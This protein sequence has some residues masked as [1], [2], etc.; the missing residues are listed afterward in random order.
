MRSEEMLSMYSGYICKTCKHDFVV[1][2][3]DVRNMAVDRFLACPFC[4]SKRVNVD[5]VTDSLKD[6]MSE[7]SYKRV[8]GRVQQ[9]R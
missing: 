5:K 7:H 2:S 1:L 3:E 8:N 9:T 4:N 6:C